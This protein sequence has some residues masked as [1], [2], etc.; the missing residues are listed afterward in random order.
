MINP[1]KTAA[2]M[3][4]FDRAHAEENSLAT[5]LKIK[6]KA[7]LKAILKTILKPN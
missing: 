1:A 5:R 2:D 7:I 6:L 4:S 3:Q